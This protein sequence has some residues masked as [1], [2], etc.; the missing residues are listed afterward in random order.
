M[1]YHFVTPDAF[2]ELAEAGGFAEHATVHGRSYGTSHAEIRRLWA[3]GRDVLFDIDVQGEEQLTRAYPDLVRIF[4][5]PPS[6]DELE[7][8]LRGRATDSDDQIAIRLTNAVGE[9]RQAERYDYVIV[10]DDL[11]RAVSDFH[12][13]LHAER[14][15]RPRVP[16]LV[17]LLASLPHA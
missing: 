2:A 17:D 3:A 14:C 12:A 4:I 13:I 15:R 1:A 10:N 11:D 7:R 5:M 9:L 8:R 16:A 6:M